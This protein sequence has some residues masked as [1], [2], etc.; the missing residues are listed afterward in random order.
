MEALQQQLSDA[1]TQMQFIRH[2]IRS[3]TRLSRYC[4]LPK[5]AVQEYVAIEECA[6]RSMPCRAYMSQDGN[7]VTASEQ[8]ITGAQYTTPPETRSASDLPMQ[9]RPSN[10]LSIP[11]PKPD[12]GNLSCSSIVGEDLEPRPSH[13][14]VTDNKPVNSDRFPSPDT[15]QASG[16]PQSEAG[17]TA[18]E[19]HHAGAAVSAERFTSGVQRAGMHTF[20]TFTVDQAKM[21]AISAERLITLHRFCRQLCR[22]R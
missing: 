11:Q 17:L 10:P 18:M 1:M 7:G 13:A 21:P 2:D 8:G 3:S 16:M 12:T 19:N 20:C 4:I 14:S 6:A 22:R 9:F 15:F 5:S